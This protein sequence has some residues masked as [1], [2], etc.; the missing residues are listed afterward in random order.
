MRDTL[1]LQEI[2]ASATGRKIMKFRH[3]HEEN[4]L[5]PQPLMS[6]MDAESCRI[7][8]RR[9]LIPASRHYGQKSQAIVGCSAGRGVVGC[10]IRRVVF[11]LQRFNREE[12][13]A[14]VQ[15]SSSLEQD[16]GRENH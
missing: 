11:V 5:Q 10:L 16:R 8:C 12:L 13:V 3:I 15:T 9:V 7:P 1:W 2:A 6:S 14:Y 4:D